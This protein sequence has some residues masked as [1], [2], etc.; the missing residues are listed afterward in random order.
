MARADA[1]ATI[2][3]VAQEDDDARAAA[4]LEAQERRERRKAV[5]ERRRAMA[6]MKRDDSYGQ[7]PSRHHG[8]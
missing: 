5:K 4:A 2:E 3:R 8:K 1:G 7:A 6:K